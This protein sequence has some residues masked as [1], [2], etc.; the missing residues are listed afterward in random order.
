MPTPK[1][2][3]IDTDVAIG[4]G[5]PRQGFAD[6]DDAWAMVHLFH[7][8]HIEVRGV[9]TVFGNTDIDNATRLAEEICERFGPPSLKVHRGSAESIKLDQI[10]SNPG[11]EAMIVALEQEPL[12]IMAIGPA[13]NVALCLILRPDLAS[14]ILSVVL[15]AGRRSLEQHFRVSPSHDPA[16]PDLNFDLDP[17]AFRVLLQS[18]VPMVLLPFEISHKTWIDQADLDAV[19]QMGEVGEYLALNSQNWLDLWQEFGCKAFNPFDI[20]ASA[21]LVDETAFEWEDW[22]YQLVLAWDDTVPGTEN[23][24]KR[25]KPYFLLNEGL[26]GSRKIRYC[27][28]PPENF[29]Q[30]LLRYMAKT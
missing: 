24:S 30:D 15:V 22:S 16:F 17:N 7:A 14:Q 5:D 21:Y 13:T 10:G 11:V 18:E 2:V 23:P 28:T 27:H 12:H 26:S 25:L 1:T 20:L 8:P 4:M 3:W 29:K 6:V 19:R 9:S